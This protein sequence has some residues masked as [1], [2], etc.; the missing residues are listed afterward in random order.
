MFGS[1]QHLEGV[2]DPVPIIQGVL[3]SGQELKPLRDEFFCQLIKQTTRPPQPGG[4][5]NLCNW[6]ILACMSCTFTPTRSILR[7]LKFH[8]KRCVSGDERKIFEFRFRILPVSQKSNFNLRTVFCLRI[9]FVLL[10]I[11]TFSFRIGI[12]YVTELKRVFIF[13]Q[14]LFSEFSKKQ[15]KEKNGRI[16]K[17][18]SNVPPTQIQM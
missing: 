9:L 2:A 6:K 4:A 12:F 3:Q 5:G 8:L 10:S 17:K 14:F 13:I 18:K 15:V 7:Y 1:L 16:L 11:V